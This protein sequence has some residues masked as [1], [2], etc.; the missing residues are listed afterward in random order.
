MAAGRGTTGRVS[1]RHERALKIDPEL[2]QGELVRVT[3]AQNLPEAE[4]LQGLLLEHGVPSM[5]IRSAGFDVPEFLAAGPRDVLVPASGV[6]VARQVLRAD[7][8]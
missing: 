2:A 7:Q 5:L 3:I 8:H 4:M 6:E 1:E